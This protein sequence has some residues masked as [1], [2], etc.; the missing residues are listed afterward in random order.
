MFIFGCT[1]FSMLCKLFSSC[2]MLGLLSSCGALASRCR[3]QALDAWVSTCGSQALEHRLGSYSMGLAAPWHE[4][5]S[6]SRCT[7]NTDI[8]P[9]DSV[10]HMCLA[11]QS[12]PALCNTMDCS[13]P[14]SSVHGIFQARILEW[15]AMSF[16]RGSSLARD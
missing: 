15:V 9:S 8:K 11:T 16:S 5:S 6:L 3:T 14:G 2:N 7:G 10:I 12:C 13:P 1:G 4:E